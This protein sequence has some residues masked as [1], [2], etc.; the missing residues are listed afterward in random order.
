MNLWLAFALC[1]AVI[2]YAGIKLSKYGDIIAEKTG[3]GGTW[4]GVV[5]MASVTS[6]PELVTGVSSVTFANVPDIAV[7]D[8]LGSCVFNLLILAFLDLLYRPLPISAK[9]HRG[10]ILSATFGAL[11]LLTAAGGL[12]AGR[13]EPF[14]GWIGPYTIVI[15]LLYVI[16]MRLVFVYEKRRSA[17]LEAAEAE[18]YRDSTLTRALLNYAFNALLVVAAAMFLPVIGGR[19]AEMTGLS[20]TFVGNALVAV[21]T[22]L[23][24][25]VVSVAAVRMGAID[26]AIGNLFGSNMFNLFLLAVDDV[27]FFKGPLLSFVDRGNLVPAFAAIAMT[28]TAIIGLTYR[29]EKKRLPLAWDSIA[30]AVIFSVNV[31]YLWG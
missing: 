5:L 21:S 11:M 3:M 7:G 13:S 10:H 25:V 31:W 26:L 30:I 19:I 14:L 9:A 1:S 20:Q 27:L 29:A 12:M 2:V 24:E 17:V 6:L 22:S 15:A 23:P 4:T 16:A 8:I 18:K 28:L